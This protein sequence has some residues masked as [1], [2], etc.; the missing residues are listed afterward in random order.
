MFYASKRTFNFCSAGEHRVLN[1]V[2]S[3]NTH[4]AINYTSLAPGSDVRPRLTVERCKITDT[5]ASAS[6]KLRKSAISLDIQDNNF[7]LSN[8]FIAGNHLGAIHARLGRSDG[9]YLPRSLIYGNTLY[10]N[11]NGT[12]VVEQRKGVKTNCSLVYIVEN[13]FGSNL[14]HDSTVKLSE[15]QSEITK[16]FFYNNSGLYSIEYDFSSPWQ[17]EQKCELNTFFLNKGLGQNYG[18]TVLSNGPMQYHRNNLKNP[19]N[20]YE[21]SSTRQAVSDSIDAK[22]NWWGVG[23]EPAVGLRIYEKEDDNRLASVEYKPF[24]KLPPRDILSRE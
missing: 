13:A 24:S 5:P 12:V 14:G 1:S 3:G 18:E 10:K 2:F 21:L 6:N 8:N 15:V 16:N 11:A 4:Q 19:S 9:T 7:T 22:E 23:I 20:L 17:K